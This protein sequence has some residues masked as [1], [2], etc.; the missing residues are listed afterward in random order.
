MQK[1]RSVAAAA[2]LLSIVV[3]GLKPALA[4]PLA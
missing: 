3:V 1:G 2:L 4:Q